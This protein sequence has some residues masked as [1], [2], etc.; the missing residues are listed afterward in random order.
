[1][2]TDDPIMTSCHQLVASGFY[3]WFTNEH[4]ELGIR[5]SNYG[6]ALDEQAALRARKD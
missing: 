5:R 1:M 3:E 6:K 2:T 4:G